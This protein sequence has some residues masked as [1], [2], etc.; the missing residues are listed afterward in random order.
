LRLFGAKIGKGVLVRP[1]ATITYPWKVAIGDY[2][3][4]GDEVI[5]YSLGEIVIGEHAVISQRSHL[6][7]GTHDFKRVPFDIL[8]EK[9]S[10]QDEAWIAAEVFVAPGITVGRGTV[11]GARSS[12]FNDLPP[13]SECVGT[14]AKPVYKR[15]PSCAF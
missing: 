12:V 14:P 9:I 8:A 10:V 1:T 15:E 3:W 13:M 2:S 5:L 4:I 7:T 11:V 6:C